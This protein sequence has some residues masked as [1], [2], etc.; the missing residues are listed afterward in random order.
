MNKKRTTEEYKNELMLIQPNVEV[1]DEYIGADIPIKHKCKMHNIIFSQR[2]TGALANQCGCDDCKKIKM[3]IGASSHKKTNGEFIKELKNIW[4]DEIIPLEEYQIS[5]TKIRF[6]HNTE[7]PHNFIMKPVNITSG[8]QGCPVCAGKQICI[9]YNDIATTNPYIAS[10]FINEEDTHKYTQHSDNKTD[11]KCDCCGKSVGKKKITQIVNKN[12]V[13]CINCKDGISYP[14]KFIYNCLKQIE[15][16][17]RYLDREVTFDW[18]EFD[19]RNDKKHGR[20][21]IYFEINNKKYIIEM[22]GGLGHGERTISNITEKETLYIDE[23]KDILAKEHDIEV[24]RI[25]CSYNKLGNRYEHIKNNIISSKL[26]SILDLSHIDFIQCD[27]K[28]CQSLLIEACNLWNNGLSV[29]KI[30]KELKISQNTIIEYLKAGS[31]NKLCIGYS[32]KASTC[33][34]KKVINLNDNKIFDSIAD[35][36]RYYNINELLIGRCCRR[37]L[38]FGGWYNGEKQIWMYNEEYL[39]LTKE[40]LKNYI[41]K[42]SKG[43]KIICL[44]TLQVFEQ[45]KDAA[46][47][48]G[49]KSTASI[50]SCCAKKRMSAGKHPETGESLKWMY[51]DEYIKLNSNIDLEEYIA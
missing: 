9:G 31:K 16:Q 2:P 18:C 40:E 38:T 41:P 5:N 6:L 11:F 49:L 23:Q 51:Y 10:L 22:D 21:D 19:F 48:C 34:G 46:K 12:G 3:K 24:I 1:I 15:D 36:S 32:P 4:G 13:R 7:K 47:W 26:S 43:T 20:Y 25:D 42:E 14:N 27:L 28:S 35:A 44:N 45:M 30:A 39:K 37:Q 29:G 33:D 17:L 8:K 50:G